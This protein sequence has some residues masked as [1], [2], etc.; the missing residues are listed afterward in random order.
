MTHPPAELLRHKELDDLFK[1]YT[2][3]RSLKLLPIRTGA[4]LQYVSGILASLIVFVVQQGVT[5]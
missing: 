5:K 1:V 2:R 3:Y 4:V